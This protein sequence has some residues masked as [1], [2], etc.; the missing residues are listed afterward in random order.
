MHRPL[1]LLLFFCALPVCAVETL[2]VHKNYV[3]GPLCAMGGPEINFVAPGI[4]AASE[5]LRANNI[6]IVRSYFRNQPTCQACG[7]CPTY[8]REILFEIEADKIA[9]AEKAGF[10]KLPVAPPADELAGFERSKVYRPT[11]DLPA[12]E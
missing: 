9:A 11:S 12:E 6:R 7:K 3:G 4:E 5:P 1:L 8:H 2:W 10:V